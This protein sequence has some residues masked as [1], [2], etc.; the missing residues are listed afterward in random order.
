MPGLKQANNTAVNAGSTSLTVTCAALGTGNLVVVGVTSDDSAT[1]C[2]LADN[3]G[4]SY[5]AIDTFNDTVNGNIIFSFF[6]AGVSGGATSLKATYGGAAPGSRAM[7]MQEWTGLATSSALDVHSA[8]TASGAVCTSLLVTTTINGEMVWGMAVPDTGAATLTATN[9]FS[10]ANQITTPI[11]YCDEW[12]IQA[13]AGGIRSS[14]NLSA[15]Q[16]CMIAVAAFK[17]AV[18]ASQV[19][20]QPY[21][22]QFLAS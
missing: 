2:T 5:T 13:A 8:H 22:Q 9:P 12:Q 16:T 17:P 4:S 21:F 18:S 3:N 6:L 15:S 19:P 20:F 10:T 7:G 14:F 11:D 1:S